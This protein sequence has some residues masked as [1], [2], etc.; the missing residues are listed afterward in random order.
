MLNCPSKVRGKINKSPFW[1]WEDVSFA[2]HKSIHKAKLNEVF[3]PGA[4]HM[5]RSPS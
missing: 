2:G 4:I 3:L 1:S 5:I